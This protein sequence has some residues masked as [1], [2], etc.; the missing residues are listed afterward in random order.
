M[1]AEREEELLRINAEL[2]AEIRRLSAG[3]VHGPRAETGPAA[4]RLSR[5]L[6]EREELQAERDQLRAERNRLQVQ[7]D[8]QEGRIQALERELRERAVQN[9]KLADEVE[10]LGADKLG[11]L[12]RLRTGLLRRR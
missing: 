2:A 3:E 12:T 4:R 10:R 7:L 6:G 11:P 5:L 1:A 8:L 9:A